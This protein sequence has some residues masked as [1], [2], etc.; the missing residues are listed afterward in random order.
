MKIMHLGDLHI[1][2]S[3]NG[4]SMIEDQLYIL[5][6]IERIAQQNK[7]D[8]LLISGDVYDKSLPSAEAVTVFDKF[9]T[10]MSR[11]VSYIFI[12][13]GN[14]DSAERL[15]FASGLMG[16]SNVF[17]ARKFS[18]TV[19][20]VTLEDEHG[21]LNVYMLPF[22][23]PVDVRVVMDRDD[24]KTY[25]DAVRAAV[26]GITPD[27]SERNIIMAHQ[28]ITNAKT[29]GSENLTVGGLE[30]VDGEIFEDF[31]YAALGHIH[32]PQKVTDKI[33]YSGSILK[34]SA[35]EAGSEKSVP[36]IDMGEKGN[37]RI[38]FCPLVPL[39]DMVE[40]KGEYDTLMSSEYY[41]D[42]NRD[43]YIVAK[44]TDKLPVPDAFAKLRSVYNNIMSI[45]YTCQEAA[46]AETASEEPLSV[47]TDPVELVKQFYQEMYGDEMDGEREK[48]ITDILEE[49]KEV[50]CA[51]D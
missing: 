24:I 39:R 13:S 5:S 46:A 40:I 21:A 32:R 51:S 44:L 48:I 50:S 25:N 16:K 2:K 9:L 49:I 1:G 10:D 31:D 38:S 11:T 42:I 4:F 30:N 36:I 28:F 7:V 41:K 27:S 33:R 45:S 23:K 43:N 26:E 22:I 35:S 18:G 19:E 14:H 37:I 6:Q 20:K 8:A 12:I 17:I 3:V 29:G 34:Y 47:S 15:S